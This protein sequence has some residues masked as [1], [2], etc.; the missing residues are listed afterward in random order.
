MLTTVLLGLLG[1]LCWGIAPIFGKMGLQNIHPVDGLSART[2][3]TLAFLLIWVVG[4]GG[5]SRIIRMTGTEWFLI[6]MEAFLATLAGDLAYYAALKWGSAAVTCVALSA[7]P[8]VT[9]YVSSALLH[10]T[11]S[12]TQ[13]LGVAMVAVGI[14]LVA[15]GSNGA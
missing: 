11:F 9:V 14:L 7:A 6:G 5:Y 12:K 4:T 1:A 8:V 13:L 2:A 15:G 10:E 3:V